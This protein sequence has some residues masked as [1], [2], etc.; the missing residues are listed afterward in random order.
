LL[1]RAKLVPA[2]AI[3]RVKLVVFEFKKH[4]LKRS[5]M[6][7]KDQ[8]GASIFPAPRCHSFSAYRG[9][10]CRRHMQALR[11]R[12]LHMGKPGVRGLPDVRRVRPRCGSGRRSSGHAGISADCPG[13]EGAPCPAASVD[14]LRLSPRGGAKG[15]SLP[16]RVPARRARNPPA[17]SPARGKLG[18]A[19]GL[20]AAASSVL[21]RSGA[22]VP[23]CS[24][25]LQHLS[26]ACA[27]DIC[28]V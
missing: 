5:Q 14:G 23:G 10:A 11:D 17:S 25:A 28:V 19:R 3:L 9:H 7:V 6:V 8:A 18:Q 16:V 4:L 22:P 24:P 26:A 20:P 12:S 15:S 27:R 21:H 1:I 2:D 13:R